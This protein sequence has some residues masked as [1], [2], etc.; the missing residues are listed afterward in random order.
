MSPTLST[1]F[2]PSI[3]RTLLQTLR[4]SKGQNDQRAR[5]VQMPYRKPLAPAANSH[6]QKTLKNI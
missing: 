1:A 6:I 4:H 5:V 3:V 2:S